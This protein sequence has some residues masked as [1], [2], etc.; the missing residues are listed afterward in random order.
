MSRL[1]IIDGNAI[2]HR[3]FHALPPLTAPDGTLV[4]AVYGFSSM[5]LRLI[6]DLKP[7]HL[8]VAFDR[9]KPTF[10]KELY[11]GYQ[12][13]R[14][15]MDEGLVSQIPL[16]HSVVAAMGIPIAELDGYEA[17]DVI[18]TLVRTTAFDPEIESTIIVTGDRDIL[19]LVSERVFTFMPTKGLSEA[20]LYGEKEALERLGIPP[21]QIPDYKALAGD[22][23]DNYP[24]V[25]GIGPKTA[26]TILKLFGSI[27]AMYQ[28]LD[29]DDPKVNELSPAV[30]SKLIAGRDIAKLSK[31]LATIRSDAPMEISKKSSEL[32]DIATPEAVALLGGFGFQ[33]LVKRLTKKAPEPKAPKKTADEKEK[34]PDDPQMSL[35]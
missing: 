15:K 25:T 3:A 23:S 14:P 9:P 20:K 6:E 17:D 34:K 30:R 7:T 16:V 1:V 21:K 35:L 5:L 22:Q 11:E 12:I 2:L 4:N 29:D 18:G 19:Q 33:S 8:I 31:N 24:G 32:K 28:A 26:V 13:K 10:R 27:E